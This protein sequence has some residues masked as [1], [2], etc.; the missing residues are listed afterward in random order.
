MDLDKLEKSLNNIEEALNFTNKDYNKLLEKLSHVDPRAKEYY[1]DTLEPLDREYRI[2]NDRYK[3]LIS[4]Y[5][6]AYLEMSEWYVGEYLPYNIFLK[7]I[8]G[9]H[10][11]L[12]S[13]EDVKELYKLFGIMFLFELSIGEIVK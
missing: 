5:S 4:Q 2:Y 10:T 9:I 11:Y 7:E 13:K 12:D 1:Y 6:L 3:D 8:K